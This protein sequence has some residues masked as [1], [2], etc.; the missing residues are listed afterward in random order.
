MVRLPD[1]LDNA[2]LLA[3]WLE[4]SAM[5]AD[6]G[7]ASAGDLT[8]ALQMASTSGSQEQVVLEAMR[9]LEY[10]QGATLEAYPFEVIHSSVLQYSTDW[11]TCVPYVFCLCL[12]YF[13][14][15]QESGRALIARKLFED[16]SAVAAEQYIHGSSMSFGRDCERGSSPFQ[17]AVDALCIALREGSG[18]RVISGKKPKDDKVDIVAWK[19]FCDGWPS[20][21]VLFG[22]CATGANWADKVSEM[23][24]EV[25]WKLWIADGNVS[26]LLRS[27]FMP[28]RI[29]L[30]DWVY[31]ASYSGILFDRCRIAFW[32]Q[33]SES[34]IVDRRCADWCKEAFPSL[35]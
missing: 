9:E 23:Q 30:R 4:L 22:Q 2:I 24:P 7:N 8:S 25:F 35:S 6:D 3:D 34:N 33:K 1:D 5:E 20:Q 32:A 17:T 13:A 31:H 19:P 28:H 12:S 10:R 11:H 16:L 29:S 21:L 26:T 15:M 14:R 18:Y 27:F